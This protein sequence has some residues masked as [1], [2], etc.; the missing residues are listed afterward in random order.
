MV[1]WNECVLIYVA[2]SGEN[3]VLFSWQ[4][5]QIVTEQRSPFLQYTSTN[6]RL[7]KLF[8]QQGS[9][10]SRTINYTGCV[11][12][13][14][15][16]IILSS[17]FTSSFGFLLHWLPLTIFFPSK[18]I[19]QAYIE[20]GQ[21]QNHVRSTWKNPDKVKQFCTKEGELASHQQ[22]VKG[23]SYFKYGK[24]ENARLLTNNFSSV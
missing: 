1:E 12:Q 2:K 6:T 3:G 10:S 16:T 17:T 23:S 7:F 22:A 8:Q 9:W 21:T 14:L 18:I 19:H 11:A 24:G 20:T 13:I 4:L 15:S 5:Q